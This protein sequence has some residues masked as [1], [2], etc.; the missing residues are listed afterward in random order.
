MFRSVLLSLIVHV[1]ALAALIFSFDWNLDENPEPVNIVHARAVDESK[2]A[3]QIQNLKK[4]E[5]RKK[6]EEDRRLAKL[7]KEAQRARRDRELQQQQLDKLKQKRQADAKQLAE[8]K[9]K[10][11]KEQQHQQ[12]IARQRE[13]ESQRLARIRADKAREAKK[14]KQ[15]REKQR[16]E[17]ELDYLQEQLQAEEEARMA[18]LLEAEKTVAV[19]DPRAEMIA[20]KRDEYR[21]QLV[22]LVW[23]NWRKP[24]G[25]SDTKGLKCMVKVRLIPTGELAFVKVTRGSGNEQF[26]RSVETAVRKSAPFP[27]PTDMNVFDGAR[28]INFVFDPSEST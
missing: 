22:S 26:D 25:L 3:K 21:A 23:R 13:A 10:Q 15:Q 11:K 4:M 14:L 27:I 8:L 12:E 28:E 17:Q 7:A 16:Q 24:P 6:H 18:A 1:G 5:A 19:E 9:Q 20:T 2:I